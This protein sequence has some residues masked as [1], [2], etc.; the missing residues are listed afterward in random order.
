MR[1]TTR[2]SLFTAIPAVLFCMALAASLWGLSRTQADFNHYIATDQALASDL[3]ELYAQ[4]LQG[5][6]ALRNIVLDPANPQALDNLRA[7]R[8]AY[9][10]A[11]PR[12][13][14]HAA[15]TP[16]A[17]DVRQLQDLRAAQVALQDEVVSLARSDQGAAVQALNS[18][19]TPAW[20][21]LRTALLQH[22]AQARERAAAAHQATGQR[23]RGLLQLALALAL[24]LLAAVVA[25]VLGVVMARTV[26]R[27]L[28]G[29]P[30]DACAVLRR[31][32]QGDLAS[33]AHAGAA[34]VGLMADL[35]DMQAALR[36]LVAQV[37]D[38]TL[39]ISHASSE[40]AQGNH[41]L[42]ARTEQQASALEETAASMEELSST[43]RQN[44][45][46][47]RQASVLAVGASQV[48]QQ[49]G[50]VVAEV[51]ATMQGINDSARKIGDIIGVI[52]SIAFQTNILALNAAVE[53]ARAGEQ[54]RGFAVV[55]SEVRTLAQRSAEAAR[56][57]RVLIGASVERVERGSALVDRAGST[58][59]EVVQ[60]IARV[61][62]IVS[63]ISA[64]S[65]EQSEGVAQI[66]EAVLHMDRATQ[67][68][69]ALVEQSTAASQSL[70][71][72]AQRLSLAVQV[73]RLPGDG[74]GGVGG[75]AALPAPG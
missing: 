10:S 46:N 16:L 8:K 26:G 35:V 55:A 73:F 2:L 61:S 54:G 40:I 49:G 74:A 6:Q 29:D 75:A 11:Y 56:E 34:P 59:G 42:S 33:S 7:S 18:R 67:Q 72:Q 44:A 62:A 39:T 53:A 1:F 3:S 17:A 47:A 30:A 13:Q 69:A 52:D 27:A 45:D 71:D 68:N 19:E 15:G 64:A 31:I 24:A 43:V 38:S 32:A 28:G 66:G 12:V 50:S 22:I 36:Q 23:A 9:D 57:I 63:E 4:G 25:G 41:D 70:S 58:M 21:K 37:R 14:Q 20:R 51:V 60:S 48:A 5:G 65:S